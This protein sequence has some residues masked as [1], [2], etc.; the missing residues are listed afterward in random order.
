MDQ[1][2]PVLKNATFKGKTAHV[3]INKEG[4]TQFGLSLLPIE[5]CR[6]RKNVV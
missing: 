4:L 2:H 3:V 6:R 5:R 1:L